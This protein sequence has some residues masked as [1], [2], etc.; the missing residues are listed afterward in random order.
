MAVTDTL[1]T[2]RSPD[3]NIDT[4]V[5]VIGFGPVGATLAGLLAQRGRSV[6]VVDRETELF[7]LPRAAHV[8]AEAMRIVQEIGCGEEMRSSLRANPGMDFLTADH[9]VLISMRSGSA[10]PYGW[11]PSNFMF[12]PDFEGRL[13]A[14]IH[15]HAAE[16]ILGV[17]ASR[18]EQ[19]PD[20]VVV[21]LDDGRSLRAAYVVGC[22][23]ARSFT[24]RAMNT[25]M[26]DL[27]FEEP[28]LVVDLALRRTVDSLPDHALQVCDASR[29]HT[30]VPMPDPRFR[31][32]F[33]LLPGESADDMQRPST[34][35]DLLAPWLGSDDADIERSAVYTFHGLVA[36][37]W[38]D[39]R[40]F[41]AGDAAHQMPPFLGQGM[42][43]GMRDAA[44]LAWKIDAVLG[45]APSQLLDTYQAEREPHVRA[46][47][48][49]AVSF[50]RIICTTDPVVAAERDR[51]MLA[52]RAATQD[53]PPLDA[54]P[55]PPLSGSLIGDGGGALSRQPRLGEVLLDTLV[56]TKWAVITRT[57]D[58]ADVAASL[59]TDVDVMVLSAEQHPVLLEVLDV[60][61]D[62]DTGCECVVI[63]PDRYVFARGRVDAFTPPALVVPA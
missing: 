51:A 14:A 25:T 34:V 5:V 12:Q 59:W 28:W 45:G 16:T 29:P 47:I 27:G 50:G 57:D 33:M 31:F 22:D 23:G 60:H 21:H 20:H 58:L 24:R 13:R 40:V 48:D 30:V 18:I 55:L 19:H 1:P 44:N 46:I 17:G 35:Y 10:T 42:C 8:D 9:E 41:L 49:L 62:D 4:D 36:N 6:I 11:S 39:R 15:G 56:A 43:S 53:A 2:E 7:P 61:S 38:R 52:S 63:R 26:H 3:T 54:M 32:E 37:Q